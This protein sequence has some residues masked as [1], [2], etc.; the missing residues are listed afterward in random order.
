[1]ID[2]DKNN[3]LFW[4]LVSLMLPQFMPISCEESIAAEKKIQ[5]WH[6]EDKTSKTNFILK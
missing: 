1:M 2:K 6:Q 5:I 3:K 4:L